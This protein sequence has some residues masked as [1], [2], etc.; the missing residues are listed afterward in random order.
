MSIQGES[1]CAARR[2][3]EMTV[4][5]G[6]TFLDVLIGWGSWHRA[7]PCWRAL[8]DAGQLLSGRAHKIEIEKCYE[9]KGAFH[10]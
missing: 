10:G 5:C 2:A 7:K 3:R 8:A 4:G 9:L 6:P 1:A